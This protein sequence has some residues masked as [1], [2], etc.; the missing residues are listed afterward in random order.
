MIKVILVDDDYPVLEYLSQAIPW[1]D[2]GLILQGCY[3]NGSQAYYE[4]SKDMPDIIITDI[5]MPVMNGL[6]LIQALKEMKPTLKSIILSCH[7]EFH[8]AQQA[9]KLNVHEYILKESL[10]PQNLIALLI[11]L[12]SELEEDILNAERNIS[13][14]QW[15]KTKLL[16]ELL[17]QPFCNMASWVKKAKEF[18]LELDHCRYIPVLMFISPKEKFKGFVSEDLIQ[19]LIEEQLDLIHTKEKAVGMN[20]SAQESVLFFPH[21]TAAESMQQIRQALYKKF[22]LMV[23]FLIGDMC[24]NPEDIKNQVQLLLKTDEQRFYTPEGSIVKSTSYSFSSEDLFQHYAEAI[25]EFRTAIMEENAAKAELVLCK[26]IEYLQKERFKPRKVK[27]WS[28]KILLDLKLKFISLQHFQSSY[29]LEVV[30]QSIYK[31]ETI[32]QL[33]ET[34]SDFFAEYISLMNT[35]NKQPKR[36]EILK[37]QKFI[38]NNLHKKISLAEVADHLHLNASYFSRLFKKETNENFV[39]YVM[40]LKMDRAK[41]LLDQSDKTIEEVSDLLG[42]ESKSYFIKTFKNYAGMAPFE[43]RRKGRAGA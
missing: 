4:A 16:P 17:D 42:F 25:E 10:K 7:D 24:H 39:E 5:G 14:K 13:V 28:I 38:L 27:E 20:Y 11:R 41:D 30:D 6:E 19:N 26:W 36:S 43:Y 35:I 3:E 1:E 23:T 2:L 8:F 12:K 15:L 9:V 34:M 18:G 21:K 40:R 29:A 22:S 31:A 32:F 37:A 33:K